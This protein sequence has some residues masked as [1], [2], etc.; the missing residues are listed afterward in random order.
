MFQL[1]DNPSKNRLAGC[2]ASSIMSISSR[3]QL[4]HIGN[5]SQVVRSVISRGME[6]YCL[7]AGSRGRFSHGIRKEQKERERERERESERERARET[8][9]IKAC[10]WERS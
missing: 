5:A 7:L 6:E 9:I 10:L 1:A 8:E 2:S 4:W 3:R